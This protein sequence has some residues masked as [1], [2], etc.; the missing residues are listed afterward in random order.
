[1]DWPAQQKAEKKKSKHPNRRQTE[2]RLPEEG[3]RPNAQK[4]KA[5]ETAGKEDQT[6]RPGERRKEGLLYAGE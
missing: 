6:A 4:A 1:M 2:V 5:G 3:R